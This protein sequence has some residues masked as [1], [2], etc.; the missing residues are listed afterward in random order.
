[1]KKFTSTD[2]IKNE[3]YIRGDIRNEILKII[4]NNIND[5]NV[6]GKDI[7]VEQFLKILKTKLIDSEILI[8]ENVLKNPNILK[9]FDNVI[10]ELSET[11]Y[12]KYLNE[13]NKDKNL[14][15]EYKN[16]IDVNEDKNYAISLLNKGELGSFLRE[17]DPLNFSYKF[18]N[19]KNEKIKN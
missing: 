10:E 1:M 12:E 11:D 5:T 2:N 13:I 6:I 18:K 19:W 17:Y 14:V 8:L 4:E 15:D 7:L 16:I 9:S 3:K